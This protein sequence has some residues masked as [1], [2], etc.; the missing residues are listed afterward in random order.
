MGHDD[1]ALFP[2]GQRL[3]HQLC[4]G[5]TDPGAEIAFA[6]PVR[7]IAGFVLPDPLQIFRVLFHMDEFLSL[8]PAEIHLFQPLDR[9]QPCSRKQDLCSLRGPLQGGHIDDLG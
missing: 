3:V 4:K 1:Q 9:D 5:I 6:L 7:M 8:K 2:T